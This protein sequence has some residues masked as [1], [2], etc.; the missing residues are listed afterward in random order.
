M[1]KYIFS[2]LAVSSALLTSCSM[3]EAPKGVLDDQTAIE[4]VNDAFKFRNG[5]YNNI[6]SISNASFLYNLDIQADMFVGTQINGNRLGVMNLGTFTSASDDVEPLWADPYAY[7]AAVNYFLPKLEMLL[8]NDKLTDA[9]KLSLERYRGEAKFARGY[10]YWYL[11]D[12]FCPS[13]GNCD[14]TQDITGLPLV[15]VYNPTGNSAAYPSRSSLAETY[16]LIEQD[17]TDALADLEA[18]ETSG[19]ASATENLAPNASYVSSCVVEALQARLALS[20]GDYATA[21]AKAE[22]VINSGYYT[23]TTYDDYPLIWTADKGSEL[24]FV[25]YGNKDQS[26]SISSMGG[27]WINKN[28]D[29]ADYI[30]TSNALAMYE[31]EGYELYDDVRYEWFFEPRALSINGAS[32]ASPCF[33]KYPG[34]PNLN[35]G[36]DNALKNLAKPFR[37]SEMYL[38]VAEAA[39]ESNPDKANSALNTLRRNRIYNY[40]DITYSGTALVNAIRTERTR[41]MIGEGFRISDLRRWNL[42]FSRSV[43]YT[44]DYPKAADGLIQASVQT[45]YPAGDKRFILPI[46]TGEIEAN[47]NLA[48]QQNP[49]Y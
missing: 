8:A 43:N 37:L 48:G 5:I 9:Q 22:S 2:L 23:L 27:A 40:A 32:I 18:Y 33:I 11:M 28:A 13:Y 12:R 20:K 49:G 47:P 36:T 38:I 42:G 15:T 29:Q 30:G 24:M 14:P 26:G 7:I 6:R 19:A 4:S 3:D 41:E 25:A 34:N 39:A 17:L 10:Y 46:P 31:T 45:A 16:K 44:D 35:T 1:K 21:I